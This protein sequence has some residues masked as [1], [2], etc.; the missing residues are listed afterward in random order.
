[1]PLPH[2]SSLTIT[3]P[4][5]WPPVTVS[6]PLESKRV[7]LQPSNPLYKKVEKSFYSSQKAY[8]YSIVKIELIQCV[9]R[10]KGYAFNREIFVESQTSLPRVY[11][12][13]LWHGTAKENVHKIA[14]Q[15]FLRQ[16]GERQAYG[17]G[18]Y[19][20]VDSSYS[21]SKRYSVPDTHGVKR[22]FLARVLTGEYHG[23]YQ[24][25]KL[26][27]TKPGT[28]APYESVV[29]N[30][31]NP[32]MFV[33]FGDDQAYPEFLVTFVKIVPSSSKPRTTTTTTT[34]TTTTP[35]TYQAFTPTT[36]PST[37]SNSFST[38]PMTTT[39]TT[40][41]TPSTYHGFTP[42]TTPSTTSNSFSRHA[43]PPIT[44]TPTTP[45]TTTTPK[46]SSTST[47]TNA[48]DEGGCVIS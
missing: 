40:T 45:T 41:T 15:G 24:G 48:K 14:V 8:K 5:E 17:D 16:F 22:M 10:W 9:R 35:S 44:T 31:R 1:M 34:R 11:E 20:A 19:F 43:T 38:P 42:I 18:V 27:H 4:P 32:S 29:D 7:V 46:P 23:G 47:S 3:F 25:L 2:S 12:R 37:T 36:T 21:I 33:L 30:A 39:S 28:N 13:H 26:P 6:D